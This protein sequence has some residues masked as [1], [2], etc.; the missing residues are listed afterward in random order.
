M[1]GPSPRNIEQTNEK[2]LRGDIE[3]PADGRV[4]VPFQGG[5][6]NDPDV[7]FNQAGTV[8]KRGQVST[9]VGAGAPNTTTR[10]VPDS[11]GIGDS[12]RFVNTGSEAGTA[13]EIIDK[14]AEERFERQTERYM[15][16]A[17]AGGVEGRPPERQDLEVE[18]FT[19][20]FF[21]ALAPSQVEFTGKPGVGPDFPGRIAGGDNLAGVE[22]RTQRAKRPNS[23]QASGLQ[24]SSGLRT[25][26]DTPSPDEVGSKKGLGSGTRSGSQRTVLGG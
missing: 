8:K 21:R 18:D 4:L 1:G 25:G 20:R 19:D 6:I 3:G 10:L 7:F 22:R 12:G 5:D 24:L 23:R 2:I 15:E 11:P 14:I 26:R 17:A 16:R 9:S 13:Q